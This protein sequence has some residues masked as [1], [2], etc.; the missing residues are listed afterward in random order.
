MEPLP[1]KE[2]INKFN[3]FLLCG[4][5][6]KVDRTLGLLIAFIMHNYW[7]GIEKERSFWAHYIPEVKRI[8]VFNKGTSNAFNGVIPTGGQTLPI[9]TVGTK[10]L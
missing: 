10:A 9:S 7:E 4:P 8:A 6:L 1:S 5:I 3:I 2:P